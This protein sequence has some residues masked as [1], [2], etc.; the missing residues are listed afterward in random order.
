MSRNIVMIGS[1]PQKLL[2]KYYK[3]MYVYSLKSYIILGDT[4]TALDMN[5]FANSDQEKSFNRYTVELLD[6]SR[7]TYS[8]QV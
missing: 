2:V 4:E 7:V 1:L 3:Y 6:G 5:C 8:L